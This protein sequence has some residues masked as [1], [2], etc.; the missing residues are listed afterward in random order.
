M[1]EYLR[2]LEPVLTQQHHDKTK[3]MIKQFMNTTGPILQQYLIEKRDAED[4]WA[5]FIF[6]LFE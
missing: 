6:I 3:N 2:L 1:T 5:S 4:N